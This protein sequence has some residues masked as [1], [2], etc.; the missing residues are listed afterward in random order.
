MVIYTIQK[1]C[2]RESDAWLR[3]LLDT[4]DENN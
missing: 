3:S 4:A 2:L 1:R